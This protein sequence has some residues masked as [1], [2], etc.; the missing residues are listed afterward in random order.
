MTTFY[1]CNGKACEDRGLKC[2][3]WMEKGECHHTKNIEYAKNPNG[4]Y[5]VGF[6][7]D[8]LWQWTIQD[9]KE[10]DNGGGEN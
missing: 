2:S 7:G 6:D 1:L 5:L 8:S 4:L 9:M 3:G 10:G